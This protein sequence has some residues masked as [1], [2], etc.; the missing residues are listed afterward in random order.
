MECEIQTFDQNDISFGVIMILFNDALITD[1]RAERWS[2]TI[3]LDSIFVAGTHVLY[4][5]DFFLNHFCVKS[6]VPR[7]PRRDPIGILRQLGSMIMGYIPIRH[8]QESN[9]QPVPS[10][11]GADPTR[12]Q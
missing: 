5:M 11:V 8:C 6:Y 7:E 4:Y 12:P 10:Q 9:S 2:I 1:V 3:N